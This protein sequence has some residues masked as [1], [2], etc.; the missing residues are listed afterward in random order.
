MGGNGISDEGEMEES[1]LST[2][3]LICQDFKSGVVEIQVLKSDCN[4]EIKKRE[5]LQLSLNTLKRENERLTKLY[6]EYL[7]NIVDQVEHRTA[8][9]SLKEQLKR[10]NDGQSEAVELIKQEHAKKIADLEAHIR[11]LL[12]EKAT[13]EATVNHLRQDL[14]AH[15]THINYLA[16]KLDGVQL[17]LESKYKLEIQA[18]K[19]CITAEQEEKTESNEKL[20]H[21]EKE[22]LVCRSKL[23]QQ[24][25]YLTSGSRVGMLKKTNIEPKKENKILK[26]KLVCTEKD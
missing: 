17:D 7:N 18:V 21:L 24:Q 26:R 19:D 4:G 9:Q 22:L 15:R 10:L 12:V 20:Q 16:T 25:P 1:L 13:N 2:F 8:C 6:T 23:V 14:E 3:D 5:A 11:I